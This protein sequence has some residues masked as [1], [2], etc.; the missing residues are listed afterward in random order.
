M[1]FATGLDDILPRK[2][3]FG[4]PGGENVMGAMTVVTFGGGG[5]T[6]LGDLAM[7]CFEI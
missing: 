1:T 5:I 6:Q 3:R 7:K 2:P 4:I